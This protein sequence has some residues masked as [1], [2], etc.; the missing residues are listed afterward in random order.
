[1]DP[2]L[3]PTENLF[4]RL[5]FLASRKDPDGHYYDPDVVAQASYDYCHGL[6]SQEHM[7]AFLEWLAL[8]RSHQVDDML[9][10]LRTLAGVKGRSITSD[11][12]KTYVNNLVPSGAPREAKRLFE[13]IVTG[14]LMIYF[15]HP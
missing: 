13:N 14:V 10:Y 15:D 3:R 12:I 11:Q 8:P 9:P 2:A 4:L 1:M 6:L 5:C 7:R